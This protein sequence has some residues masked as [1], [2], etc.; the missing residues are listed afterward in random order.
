MKK[1][2]YKYF[3][4]SSAW[5]SYFLAENIYIKSV[6]EQSTLML[7]SVISIFEIKR[8]LLKENY[9]R[10]NVERVLAFIKSRSI[11]VEITGEIAEVAAEI[12]LRYNLHSTDSLIYAS[13][14]REES[15]LVTGD[16]DFNGIPEVKLIT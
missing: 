14:K 1:T 10:I 12:S 4:D 7:T 5:L 15:T 9:E 13:S 2:E 11:I 3:M 16:S 6:I 8:K